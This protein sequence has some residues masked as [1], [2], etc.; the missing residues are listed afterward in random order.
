MARKR[1]DNLAK[2]ELKE[3][4]ATNIGNNTMNHHVNQTIIDV[5]PTAVTSTKENNQEQISSE[6][7]ELETEV[8]SLKSFLKE[9]QK[10][11]TALRE[12]VAKLES[13]TNSAENSQAEFTRQ[14]TE[15]TLE[16]DSIKKI[17]AQLK[18]QVSQLQS[19]LDISQRSQTS[20]KQQLI[21]L[22]SDLSEQK[23]V[24]ESL[25]RELYDAKKAALHLAEANN[26]LT[27][28]L[29]NVKQEKEKAIE[30]EKEKETAIEK[31][32]SKAIINPQQNYRKSHH[33]IDRVR[34]NSLPP[35]PV[36][37]STEESDN[38]SSQMWLLD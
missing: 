17:E 38:N 35:R 26:Q 2:E 21:D 1:L 18:Q 3:T 30:K 16:R 28:E 36:S 34:P 14:L 11:E 20:L 37:K 8:N 6:Y 10:T 25:S 13:K 23:T 32:K 31:A 24:A 19:D 27:E 5:V 7:I 4:S 33:Q 22:Q 12:Q 15:L 29:N 9:A